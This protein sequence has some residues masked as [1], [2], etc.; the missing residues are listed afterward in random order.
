MARDV[1]DNA[2]SICSLGLSRTA[3]GGQQSSRTSE[4]K[5][6]AASRTTV[7]S[8]YA[9][10]TTA[11]ASRESSRPLGKASTRWANTAM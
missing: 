3:F 2:T 4:S 9:A 5:K 1:F 6:R 7:V 11:R 10:I 8:M